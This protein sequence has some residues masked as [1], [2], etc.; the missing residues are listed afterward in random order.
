MPSEQPRSK[1]IKLS[2]LI[3]AFEFVS[4]SDLDEHQ[5]YICK[6]TGKTTFVSSGVDLE[7]EME[8]L[9]VRRRRNSKFSQQR[10]GHLQP[11]RAPI[12]GSS[13]YCIRPAGSTNGMRS[14][15]RRLDRLSKSGA[16][17][18]A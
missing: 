13:S 8:F 11:K 6:S 2:E 3:E 1:P 9:D 10:Q 12:T 16:A 14:K 17:R 7:E 4:I 15:S 5:A 18:W